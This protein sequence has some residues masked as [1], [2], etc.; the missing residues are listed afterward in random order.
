MADMS[1]D[2]VVDR[3][4]LRQRYVQYAVNARPTSQKIGEV[5]CTECTGQGN[6]FELIPTVK[7][8]TRH[9]VVPKVS[10]P[11][12][13]T[14]TVASVRNSLVHNTANFSSLHL[15]KILCLRYI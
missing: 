2:S 10:V 6:D 8:E 13:V 1:R 3:H 15:F 11:Q 12:T 9:P 7:M 14:D 5:S 4:C